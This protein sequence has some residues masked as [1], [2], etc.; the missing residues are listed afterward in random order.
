MT[1]QA[2]NKSDKKKTLVENSKNNIKIKGDA[3]RY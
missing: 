2:E 3:K 1:A